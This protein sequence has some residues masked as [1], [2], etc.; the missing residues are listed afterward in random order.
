M[1]AIYKPPVCGTFIYFFFNSSQNGVR[2]SHT[3]SLG[4]GNELIDL[5]FEKG[6]G[7]EK[8]P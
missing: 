4:G 2:Q 7:Q 5:L 1:P 3:R 8:E 6:I